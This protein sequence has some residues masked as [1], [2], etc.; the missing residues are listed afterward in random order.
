MA[1]LTF[2]ITTD[3]LCVDVRANLDGATIRSLL[4]AERPVP[5]SIQAIG[6]LDT[7]TDMTA[8]AAP[9]LHQLGVPIFGQA[10]TQGVNGPITVRV[11]KVSLFILDLRLPQLPWLARPDLLVT[12]L[13]SA[14]PVDVLIGLDVLL[15]CRL[16]L[17]GPGLRFTLNF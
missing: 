10:Q 6:L 14:L 8:I 7:G 16:F 3:G 15:G 9:I 12:E 4:A 13:P 1:R 2:P 11:F 5:T 17:D